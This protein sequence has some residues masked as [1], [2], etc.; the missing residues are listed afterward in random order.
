MQPVQ[1]TRRIK[2]APPAADNSGVY[3]LSRRPADHRLTLDEVAVMARVDVETVR[4]A[5]R[6]RTLKAAQ[7]RGQ[8]LARV[9]DVRTWLAR[10]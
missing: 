6:D 4:S 2:A 3:D 5:V 1:T 7:E 10:R 9:A 8:W